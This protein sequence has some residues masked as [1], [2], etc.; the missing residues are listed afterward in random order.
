MA[1]LFHLPYGA[2]LVTIGE[3][4][5]FESRPHVKQWWEKITSRPSWQTVIAL[6]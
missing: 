5:F 2:R 1:D 4:D 6:K 3:G